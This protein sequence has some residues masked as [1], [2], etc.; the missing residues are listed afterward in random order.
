MG[1]T[2]SEEDVSDDKVNL[3]GG[4][5]EVAHEESSSSRG[6][7]GGTRDARGVPCF[8]KRSHSHLRRSDDLRAILVALEVQLADPADMA[9]VAHAYE[10]LYQWTYAHQKDAD[11]N[12]VLEALELDAMY[13]EWRRQALE[14]AYVLFYQ[15]AHEA[16][17][18]NAQGDDGSQNADIAC[19]LPPPLSSRVRKELPEG[20]VYS[21][22]AAIFSG[23]YETGSRLWK[24]ERWDYEIRMI[25]ST[26]HIMPGSDVRDATADGP[27]PLTSGECRRGKIGTAREIV[28]TSRSVR[29]CAC[30]ADPFAGMVSALGCVPGP[31]A[32][33]DEVPLGGRPPPPTRR[34]AAADLS[35]DDNE[36]V[37]SVQRSPR[38]RPVP[39]GSGPL[40]EPVARPRMIQDLNH[41]MDMHEVSSKPTR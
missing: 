4:G 10:R 17:S 1:Q 24:S 12:K 26:N 14:E 28:P 15:D 7:G 41:V 37:R 11:L 32:H 3:K 23:T 31:R 40:A 2:T 21:H 6:R 22:K 33:G 8:E 30:A 5:H 34:D 36:S 13:P 29:Y 20:G 16:A 9:S 25:G 39:L 19:L 35:D 18:R 27:Y 38:T